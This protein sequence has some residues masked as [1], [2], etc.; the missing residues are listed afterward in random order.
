MSNSNKGPRQ[1]ENAPPRIKP[2]LKAVPS[3]RDLYWCDFPQDAHLPELWKRRPVIVISFKN[4]LTGA[5]TVVPCSSMEQDGN[6]WAYKL[7]TTFEGSDSWAICDK[8]TTVAVSR[9]SM[10]KNGKKRLPEPEFNQMLALVYKWLP[11]L[12]I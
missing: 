10:D 1:K 7:I 8:P 11:V 4:Y 3:I 6:K 9:L 5:V 2:R 12:P